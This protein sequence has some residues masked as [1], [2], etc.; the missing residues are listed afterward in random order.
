[1]TAPLQLFAPETLAAMS[2]AAQSHLGP[3]LTQLE[4]FL[5]D[6]CATAKDLAEVSQKGLL[7]RF[8]DSLPPII[9]DKDGEYLGEEKKAYLISYERV[10]DT[11]EH[12]PVIMALAH[13]GGKVWGMVAPD[14]RSQGL[15]Y[16]SMVHQLSRLSPQQLICTSGLLPGPK[17]TQIFRDFMKQ[18]IAKH[19]SFFEQELHAGR[20]GEGQNM[21]HWF[22][23]M[24]QITGECSLH[25][26]GL[27]ISINTRNLD[28]LNRS[29][30]DF[31]LGEY[32][33]LMNTLL[34]SSESYFQYDVLDHLFL[35]DAF[36]MLEQTQDTALVLKVL[37][38]K[39]RFWAEKLE[40][41]N[42]FNDDLAEQLITCALF[43]HPEHFKRA[44]LGLRN[45]IGLQPERA[46]F[47]SVKDLL[48]GPLALF[49]ISRQGSNL[50]Q[51]S[52]LDR[53]LTYTKAL[54]PEFCV[55]KLIEKSGF[56]NTRALELL[57]LQG[58]HSPALEIMLADGAVPP[59]LAEPLL[60]I[61]NETASHA[62]YLPTSLTTILAT[63][64][65]RVRLSDAPVDQSGH[66][67]D[68][69][70]A[71]EIKRLQADYFAPATA[72]STGLKKEL[73]SYLDKLVGVTPEHL[74]LTGIDAADCPHIV[75]KMS[76]Q[77]QGKLFSQDLGL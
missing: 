25:T 49:S 32:E 14:T 56:T 68:D 67:S 65:D 48:T 50:S 58:G 73:I 11:Y 37:T 39:A 57:K 16:R 5:A 33:H 35:S 59:G 66:W 60:N 27:E 22:R 1:M 76:L 23:H 24:E 43:T 3:V 31:D 47:P 53:L 44:G 51:S 15:N 41:S 54:I 10:D 75:R 42:S 55:D 21:R 40:P 19:A 20:E 70:A 6:N 36:M 34:P 17:A 4:T 45:V 64:I 18:M 46:L 29:L 77:E 71:K 2:P 12:L 62:A 63:L 38:A 61:I 8:M 28:T 7:H 69:F 74:Q 72:A 13:E 9:L 26:H 30:E 52:G